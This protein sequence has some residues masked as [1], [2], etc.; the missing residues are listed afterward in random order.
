VSFHS[1]HTSSISYL[2]QTT[3]PC[4]RLNNTVFCNAVAGRMNSRNLDGVTNWS[5]Q[6]SVLFLFMCVQTLQMNCAASLG[7]GTN[8]VVIQISRYCGTNFLLFSTKIFA[9]L[10][11][12]TAL[13]RSSGVTAWIPYSAFVIR[14]IVFKL[15][16]TKTK[17]VWRY[18]Q[19][20]TPFM[21][22]G[23]CRLTKFCALD[24][25]YY[26]TICVHCAVD[27]KEL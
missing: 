15:H 17:L 25:Y 7:T 14:N 6:K 9:F 23:P 18:T 5:S 16:V 26:C 4:R 13:I 3:E 22:A 21:L 1:L 12:G 27:G 11:N 24:M 20:L 2:L 19:W 8:Y 10:R